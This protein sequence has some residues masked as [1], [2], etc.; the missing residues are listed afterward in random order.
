MVEPL[1]FRASHWGDAAALPD[2]G[3]VRRAAMEFWLVDLRSPWPR[4][5]RM[6]LYEGGPRPTRHVG[7]GER[8]PSGDRDRVYGI[9]IG[10]RR[11]RP[12]RV[13]RRC[14]GSAD[15][16]CHAR[17]AVPATSHPQTGD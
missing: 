9:W 4:P 1:R 7:F 15:V 13:P 3:G 12:R 16:H 6:R 2:A 14:L 10:T 11:W 17:P 5:D 8:V